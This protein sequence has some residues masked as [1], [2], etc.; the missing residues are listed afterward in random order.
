MRRKVDMDNLRNKLTV[1][2][3]LKNDNLSLVIECPTQIESE[4]QVN[5]DRDN[6]LSL[7]LKSHTHNRDLSQNG[8]D[9]NQLKGYAI[10][11]LNNES[12][13]LKQLIQKLPEEVDKPDEISSWVNTVIN[14]VGR[15]NSPNLMEL[16]SRLLG[17]IN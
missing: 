2:I 15:L 3:D 12:D 16:L 14:V 17:L 1:L 8:T 7:A 11:E 13:S 4:D 6:D 10:D 9:T 5:H